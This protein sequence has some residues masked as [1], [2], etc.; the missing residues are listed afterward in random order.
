MIH[1]YEMDAGRGDPYWEV[2]SDEFFAR[3][4]QGQNEFDLYLD[5]C[6][7]RGVDFCIHTLKEYDEYHLAV[8]SV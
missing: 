1:L 6:K 8:P 7:H 3:S 2:Y 4:L 5:I